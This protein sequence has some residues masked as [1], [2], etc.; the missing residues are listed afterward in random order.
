MAYDST[1][2]FSTVSESPRFYAKTD[3]SIYHDIPQITIK[4][5]FGDGSVV[6]VP[7]LDDSK[8]EA[9]TVEHIKKD[10][11]ESTE[12]KGLK[13]I[14]RGSILEDSDRIFTLA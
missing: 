12:T 14:H 13:L 3:L 6:D 8:L 7:V 2:D 5:K 11:F 9:L 4:I 1:R 10:Q